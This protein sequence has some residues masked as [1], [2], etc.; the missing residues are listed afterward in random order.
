MNEGCE[1]HFCLI[2]CKIPHLNSINLA[3]WSERCSC[4]LDTSSTTRCSLAILF[5]K[6]H[7]DVQ[8]HNH[9]P[10][11]CC[12]L[13]S[14]HSTPASLLQWSTVLLWD[15]GNLSIYVFHFVPY[16]LFNLS[17]PVVQPAKA[18]T[19]HTVWC[20]HDLNQEMAPQTF[21]PFL[22]WETAYT[23]AR[24]LPFTKVYKEPESFLTSFFISGWLWERCQSVCS[25][26]LV[27]REQRGWHFP[28]SHFHSF[29]VSNFTSS[30]NIFL[31]F[32]LKLSVMTLWQP[33]KKGLVLKL[34]CGD[35]VR[36]GRVGGLCEEWVYVSACVSLCVN[37]NFWNLG[38]IL[39]V[40]G[41]G[42]GRE[43]VEFINGFMA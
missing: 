9:V 20:W 22:L 35:L 25:M 4:K 31:F 23:F 38:C 5:S 21:P 1:V 16:L 7:P 42:W 41:S 32:H 24:L 27:Q 28:L 12:L 33:H 17:N 37:A 3:V 11:Y 6:T 14:V 8:E 36:R 29:A 40:T 2:Y 18:H 10:L 30:F 34:K 19:V 26:Q 15:Q 13:S 39:W 43:H